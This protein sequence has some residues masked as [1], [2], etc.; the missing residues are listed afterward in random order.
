MPF[1]VATSS[2]AQAHRAATTAVLRSS[3][4]PGAFSLTFPFRKLYC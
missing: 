4:I 1:S 3:E 2:A